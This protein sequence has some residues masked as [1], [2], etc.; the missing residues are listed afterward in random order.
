MT[1][2]TRDAVVSRVRTAA[3][4]AERSVTLRFPAQWDV[5]EHWPPT[6]PP[7]GEEQIR[8]SI[9]QPIGQAPIHERCRGKKRPVVV[10]DDLNRP[11][12]AWR[13]MPHV[14]EELRRGGIDPAAITIVMATGTHGAPR[15]GAF[16]K[17]VGRQAAAACRLEAHDAGRGGA[18]LGTTTYGTPVLANRTVAE[19]DFVLGIGGIYP[20]HTAGFGGGAKLALGVL[21]KSSI[22]RLHY[23]H[24]SAGWGTVD[25]PNHFR[26]DL[27]AI[28][29]LIGLHTMISLHV[30]H[31]GEIVR[32]ACGDHL[33]YFPEE[34]RFARE[35]FGVPPP[36]EADVLVANAYPNDLSL[37]FA[38]MK[39]TSVFSHGRP[40]ASRI[41]VAALTEGG[42][43]HGLFPVVDVPRFFNQMDLIREIA[44]MKPG[45]IARKAARAIWR[46]TVGRFR[47]RAARPGGTPPASYRPMWLYCTTESTP[48]LP[49]A[50]G[51]NVLASWEEVLAAVQAEQGQGRKLRVALYPCA[52]LQWIDRS[53]APGSPP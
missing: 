36:G 32:L 31:R 44:V 41:V 2:E 39:G 22:A 26:R 29:Q 23:R 5:I 51:V 1:L 12:P 3:W 14:L 16:E 35:T 49:V 28:A 38:R 50:R 15:P 4:Y 19:S 11:T 30:D 34:V 7:L 33:R 43:Y 46:R 48:R 25:G 40:E 18:R 53:R 21:A 10:V 9:G 13:V 20:N 17:K 8:A 47:Y 27:E 6:L 42:G 45:E 37:T 24:G 52:P